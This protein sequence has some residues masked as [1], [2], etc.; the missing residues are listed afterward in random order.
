M[1]QLVNKTE[2][3]QKFFPE[4]VEEIHLVSIDLDVTFLSIP[5]ILRNINKTFPRNTRERNKIADGKKVVAI[6]CRSK[7]LLPM[8][9]IIL[10]ICGEDVEIEASSKNYLLL[11]IDE[12]KIIDEEALNDL[13]NKMTI[14]FGK[15][16]R[17]II[18][19][20]DSFYVK[21]VYNDYEQEAEN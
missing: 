16:L 3:I 7:A 2:F 14:F 1:N 4:S 8:N 5:D 18:R 20:F 11:S 17:D 12:K 6:L 15:Y 21:Y 13:T 19:D 10:M 9:G